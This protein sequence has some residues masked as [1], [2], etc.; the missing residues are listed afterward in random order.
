MRTTRATW[1]YGT[2]QVFCGNLSKA[3]RRRR[4]STGRAQV[5]LQTPASSEAASSTSSSSTAG[6]ARVEPVYTASRKEDVVAELRAWKDEFEHGSS[7]L[8]H[9]AQINISPIKESDPTQ[10][11]VVENPPTEKTHGQARHTAAEQAAELSSPSSPD[12][13]TPAPPKPPPGQPRYRRRLPARPMTARPD[14]QPQL[15]PVAPPGRR[16]LPA[17]PAS[18]QEPFI[19]ASAEVTTTRR[20][21]LPVARPTTAQPKLQRTASLGAQLY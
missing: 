18:P 7:L 2:H 9:A 21:M 17:P 4:K 10:T 19:R 5:P 12:I 16:K 6:P 1:T 3:L 8:K 20:R 13:F 14:I 11:S 15:A